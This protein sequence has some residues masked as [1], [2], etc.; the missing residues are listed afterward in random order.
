MALQVRVSPEDYPKILEKIQENKHALVV[1]MVDLL[2]F[3]C[4]IWPG[5][6]DIIGT[7]F[8][9]MVVRETISKHLGNRL[10]SRTK[11]LRLRVYFFLI[12]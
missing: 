5:I 11:H 8:E 7:C 6:M 12:S 1:L 3:P 2:D 10:L 9:C 4:S